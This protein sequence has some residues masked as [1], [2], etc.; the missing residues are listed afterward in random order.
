[1]ALNE[2][3][4]Q[5][6]L[7]HLES[8]NRAAAL[9]ATQALQ[10]QVDGAKQAA[11]TLVTQCAQYVT[12]QMRA[13][14]DEQLSRSAAA[15]VNYANVARGSSLVALIAA[16]AALLVSGVGIGVALMVVR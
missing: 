15:A 11:A 16:G 14:V 9:D 6:Y 8:V 13:K 2:I 10:A 1:M 5:R 3:V 12:D 4:L 7:T